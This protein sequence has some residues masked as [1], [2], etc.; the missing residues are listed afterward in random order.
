MNSRQ[1]LIR[2]FGNY[3]KM[4]AAAQFVKETFNKPLLIA[5]VGVADARHAHAMLREMNIDR[6]YLV[7]SYPN[8]M[9]GP[10]SR[11]GELQEAYYNAMFNNMQAY[12]SKVTMI[13]RSS[14]FAASLFKDDFFDFIYIDGDHSYR[15][16]KKDIEV[17]YPKVVKG[18]I[19]AG[20]D[21]GHIDFPGV[22]KA[23]DEFAS[24]NSKEI[25]LVG[26]SEWLIMR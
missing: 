12:L 24:K 15:Q 6:L 21:I 25:I 7:D 13:T 19:L 17:W 26:D 20:H 1:A 14:V 11:K 23:V 5:E 8:Y 2:S 3:S 9:D 16:C 4:R 18:G 22:S 10:C